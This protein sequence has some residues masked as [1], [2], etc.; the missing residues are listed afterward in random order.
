MKLNKLTKGLIAA[1]ALSGASIANAGVVASSYL[2]VSGFSLNGVGPTD[3]FPLA[4]GTREGATSA[5]FNIGT[6][7]T[8]GD[9]A[10]D[11]VFAGLLPNT[12]SVDA[13]LACV[14]PDCSNLTLSENSADANWSDALTNDWNYAYADQELVGNAIGG[15]SSGFT[16]AESSIANVPSGNASS[17]G[18][19]TNEF[20]AAFLATT[21]ASANF[22]MDYVLDM[23]SVITPD[24]AF[25][26]LIT[27]TTSAWATLTVSIKN[28]TDNVDVGVWS[29]V[30][31][32]ISGR[33]GALF[34]TVLPGSNE[35]YASANVDG[36]N[37][38]NFLLEQNK[39]YSLNITQTTGT[40]T[41]LVPEPTSL[42]VFGLGLLGL[43]G[44][45][46]KRKA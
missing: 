9:S 3:L 18:S 31:E 12:A 23:A 32:T 2:E 13:A 30:N 10:A 15:A 5:Q 25:D 46:R 4:Q 35:E 41:S 28:L 17:D 34:N 6:N 44:V 27:A 43:A 8:D 42:A 7:Q 29:I 16:I 39:A 40:I 36:F 21:T 45:A 19:I 22:S 26:D 37:S 14:G 38:G 1:V 20:E 33:D 11:T 24:I